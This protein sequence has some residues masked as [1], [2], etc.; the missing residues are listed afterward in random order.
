VASEIDTLVGSI[1][2]RQLLRSETVVERIINLIRIGGDLAR[3]REVSQ[4]EFPDWGDWVKQEFDYTPT[5]CRQLILLHQKW[6]AWA[7]TAAARPLLERLPCDLAELELLSRLTAAELEEL[8]DSVDCH[9][10]TFAALRR[11]VQAVLLGRDIIADFAKFAARWE[12]R[13]VALTGEQR[14]RLALSLCME[15][16]EL[17]ARWDRQLD[18]DSDSAEG[19]LAERT[20]ARVAVREEPE[21]DDDSGDDE[22][23]QVE[24]QQ[25]DDQD[26]EEDDEEPAP[27]PRRR[28]S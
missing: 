22:D 6:G 18:D 21:A 20:A 25:N 16:D 27:R 26:D 11:E 24:D 12:S 3:L 17:L 4:E 8:L 23:E 2:D 7:E 10:L 5:Q 1:N 15:T 28:G 9:A 14:E 13:V 19:E